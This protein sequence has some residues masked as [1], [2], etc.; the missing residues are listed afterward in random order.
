[1]LLDPKR[2]KRILA[3]RESAAR[4][5]VGSFGGCGWGFL[6]PASLAPLA[7]WQRL[8]GRSMAKAEG[9]MFNH[10]TTTAHGDQACN[11]QNIAMCQ[12]K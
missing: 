6:C 3:N 11:I 1:M 7:C 4:S 8:V 2:V 10:G 5:K 12:N 9:C